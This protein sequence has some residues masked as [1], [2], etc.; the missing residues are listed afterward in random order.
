MLKKRARCYVYITLQYKHF[1][2]KA[3]HV[4]YLI[5][6]HCYSQPFQKQHLL[7]QQKIILSFLDNIHN[8]KFQ[9][10]ITLI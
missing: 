3:S 10:T 7:L 5:T 1:I 8:T 4:K 9:K 6:F 2:E